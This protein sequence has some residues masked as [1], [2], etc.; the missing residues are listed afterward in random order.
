[1]GVLSFSIGVLHQGRIFLEA[2]EPKNIADLL[3]FERA[4]YKVF[5]F[6]YLYVF[7]H[8]VWKP[9]NEPEMSAGWTHKYHK[10][11]LLLITRFLYWSFLYLLSF[12]GIFFTLFLCFDILWQLATT[13]ARDITRDRDANSS[14]QNDVTWF[15]FLQGKQVEVSLSLA[16]K[17]IKNLPLALRARE[18]LWARLVG[19]SKRNCALRETEFP[20]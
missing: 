18:R 19:K 13:N 17:N 2:T 6:I 4:H 11:V 10:S 15:D 16:A 3:S 1:M 20:V 12:I 9:C 14:R 8:G 5:I 7:F